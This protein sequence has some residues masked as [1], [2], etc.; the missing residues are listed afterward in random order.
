MVAE[1]Q[2]LLLDPVDMRVAPDAVGVETPLEHRAW[3]VQRARNDPVA[4]PVRVGANVDQECASP[5]CREGLRWFYP[6]DP[7]LRLGNELV[8]GSPTDGGHDGM[9]WHL[10]LG[11]QQ[12]CPL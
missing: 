1:E 9:M 12:L 2:D 10:Q 7:R 6:L 8:E 5:D 3:D 11:V 4:L